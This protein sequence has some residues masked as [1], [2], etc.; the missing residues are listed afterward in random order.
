MSQQFLWVFSKIIG[1]RNSLLVQKCSQYQYLQESLC[2][3]NSGAH[4]Q[5]IG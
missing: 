3:H 1:N 5:M 2:G 4:Q